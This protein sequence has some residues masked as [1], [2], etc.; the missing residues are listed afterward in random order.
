[1][2]KLG[3][4][5]WRL[6]GGGL[7]LG[8]GGREPPASSFGGSSARRF[9]PTRA[10]SDDAATVGA[11]VAA[12]AAFIGATA[13]VGGLGGDVT[14][15]ERFARDLSSIGVARS[16]GGG[17]AA[18]AFDGGLGNLAGGAGTLVLV[19]ETGAVKYATSA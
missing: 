1:M 16:G 3:P 14:P 8:F 9:W 15:F 7:G 2:N 17:G 11:S 18:I 5:F 6:A 12:S 13:G 10:S 19:L 4:C